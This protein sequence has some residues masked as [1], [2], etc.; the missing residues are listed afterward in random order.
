MATIV[1]FHGFASTGQSSKV[2]ELRAALPDH[3][4]IA[5]DLAAK[6]A[7]VLVQIDQLIRAV[8]DFP[9]IFVGTSLGG[10]WA[11]YFGQ[12]YDVPHVVVNPSTQ[13]S[14]TMAARL[15][16]QIE[17]YQT[18]AVFTVDSADIGCYAQL[19]SEIKELYNGALVHLFVARDDDVL[20]SSVAVNYF[21]YTASKNIFESGGHRFTE[22]WPAVVQYVNNFLTVT[23]PR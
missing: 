15:G 17:N 10:F 23:T 5:P 4:V 7:D 2:D 11:S 19:E 12:K 14:L 13:P 18:G 3:T 16:K 6:P 1:Y 20:D 8:L 22:N 9:L 21:K